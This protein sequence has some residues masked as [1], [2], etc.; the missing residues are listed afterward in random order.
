MPQKP[1]ALP[2]LPEVA[3]KAVKPIASPFEKQQLAREA[4]Q[5]QTSQT[6]HLTLDDNAITGA[7]RVEDCSTRCAG[8]IEQGCKV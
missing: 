7:K 3:V 2:E 5:V 1:V 8:Q 6:T 4:E